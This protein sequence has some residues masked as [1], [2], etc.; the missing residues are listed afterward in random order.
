MTVDNCARQCGACRTSASN[1]NLAGKV[2]KNL[3]ITPIQPIHCIHE[4]V[5]VDG[6]L[7]RAASMNDLLQAGHPTTGRSALG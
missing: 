7:P 2:G 1:A 3:K 5:F 6:I 4:T